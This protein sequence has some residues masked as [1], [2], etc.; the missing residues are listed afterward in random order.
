MPWWSRLKWLINVVV[1][2]L[3]WCG[4]LNVY[5]PRPYRPSTCGAWICDGSSHGCADTQSVKLSPSTTR[6]EWVV[7][8][9][10]YPSFWSYFE[11]NRELSSPDPV[12][13][14]SAVS[15]LQTKKRSFYKTCET[16]MMMPVN[17]SPLVL[18]KIHGLWK[19]SS[20]VFMGTS[21]NVT[22]R[23]DPGG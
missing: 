18:V 15:G 19:R 8:V 17:F 11:E 6:Q 12:M 7:T 2:C 23:Y 22:T 13:Q 21:V 1:H 9:A 10:K 3:R 5:V 4:L 14:K 16:S 20:L